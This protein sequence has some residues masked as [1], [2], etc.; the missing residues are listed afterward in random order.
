MT[1]SAGA[2]IRPVT[3]PARGLRDGH[4]HL[5]DSIDRVIVTDVDL[6][7]YLE[8]PHRRLPVDTA[9][10][11]AQP[12]DPAVA[13]T[14]GVIQRLEGS[15]LAESRAM[16][17]TWTGN[18]A[19]VTAFLATWLVER[20]WQARALR[21]VLTLDDPVERPRPFA[22]AGP[23]TTLR[24]IHVAR[25]Q[26]LL[27]PLWTVLVGEA[28]TAGHMMRLAVQETWLREA[29]TLLAERLDGEARR[30]ALEVAGRHEDAI[31]FLRAEATARVTRSRR[32][33]IAARL[34]LTL[35]D[36]LHG[37]GVPD[38]DLPAALAELGADPAALA[39]LDRARHDLTRLLPG[40]DLPLGPSSRVSARIRAA[41]PSLT[42]R[43][44]GT[45]A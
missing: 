8:T 40:A 36:P 18:E 41:L 21:D 4:L 23:A 25:V 29:L 17:A 13:R 43:A 6:D 44:S 7:G 19:R 3:D 20:Y 39:A 14:L 32:E 28:V 42:A 1:I 22:A 37:G 12:L 24:R 5:D 45:G 9:A 16:L 27:S 38:P 33:A 31:E 10:V 34:V 2:T 11:A 26:P 35:D 30:V 15:A